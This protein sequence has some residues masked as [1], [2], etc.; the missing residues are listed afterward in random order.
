MFQNAVHY[1]ASNLPVGTKICVDI[2]KSSCPIV[3]AGHPK[4]EYTTGCAFDWI[5]T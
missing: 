3:S 2:N 5:M 1:E 4:H